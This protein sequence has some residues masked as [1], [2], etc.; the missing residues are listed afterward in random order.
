MTR[1]AIPLVVTLVFGLGA[2][3]KPVEQAPDIRPVRVM[4]VAPVSVA[5][6]FEYAGEV[7]PRVEARLGFRVPGKLISRSVDV[8]AVVTRGQ[9]LATL[10]PRDLQLAQDAARAQLAAARVDAS[11]ATADLRRTT[12][13]RSKGFISEAELERRQ[14]AANAARARLE[15]AEALASQQGNQTGYAALTADVAGVVTAIEAE[16]GQVVAAGQAVIRV[17]PDGPREVAFAIPEDK[18]EAVRRIKTVEVRTWAMPARALTARVREIAPLADPATRTFAAR[19]TLDKTPADVLLGMT[20]TVRF[21]GT[22]G[23]ARLTVPLVAVVRNQE[24]SSVWVLDAA[25][26][27]VNLSNVSLGTTVGNDV[28][29]T[30]GLQA[31]QL[32]VTAGVHK[33][34]PGQKVARL[35][36]GAVGSAPAASPAQGGKS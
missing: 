6:A 10:D 8:G 4:T 7:R 11:L 29:I 18:V 22:T 27:T 5:N 32:V 25:T 21:I 31:G 15:Q 3:Q 26:S 24:Q 2:C 19:V 20:A 36:D 33:L 1:I 14:S 30:Q 13:L 9:V 35:P 16:V 17:A 23:P 12:D 28:V 34:Q